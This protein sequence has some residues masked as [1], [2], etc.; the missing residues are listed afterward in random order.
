MHQPLVLGLSWSGDSIVLITHG[1]WHYLDN[2]VVIGSGDHP[3]SLWV[4]QSGHYKWLQV[5]HHVGL[6]K[7]QLILS[8]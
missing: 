1:D 3:E 7:N 8:T 5:I 4:T 2:S 6:V